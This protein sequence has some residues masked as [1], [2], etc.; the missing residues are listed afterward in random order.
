MDH[1]PFRF[2]KAGFYMVWSTL[3]QWRYAKIFAFALFILW[4][5][6]GAVDSTIFRPLAV[7]LTA[8]L[9]LAS[10]LDSVLLL[11]PAKTLAWLRRTR[12]EEEAWEALGCPE[13]KP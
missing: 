4:V 8:S 10:L 9:A 12:E 2:Q 5:R 13:V 7:A 3:T 1:R 11:L 6:H